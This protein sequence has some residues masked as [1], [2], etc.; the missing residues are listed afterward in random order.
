M[1]MYVLCIVNRSTSFVL[2]SNITIII[3]I[4]VQSVH[5][6]HKEL[7]LDQRFKNS[8]G[9]ISGSDDDDGEEDE[10]E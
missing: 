9:N 4:I 8:I 3:I 10:K 7:R 2:A 6:L 5:S 1:H